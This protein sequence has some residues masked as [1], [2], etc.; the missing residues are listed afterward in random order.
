MANLPHAWAAYAQFQSKLSRLHRLNDYSWGLEGA[1]NVIFEPDF[2]PHLTGAEEFR[3]AVAN[4]SRKK[5]NHQSRFVAHEEVGDAPDPND[6][7]AQILAADALRVIED[8]INNPS[9]L[10]LID[11][12]AIGHDYA[13]LAPLL[14]QGPVSLRSRAMRLR[15]R[16]AHLKPSNMSNTSIERLTQEITHGQR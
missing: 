12:I 3:R 14:G 2:S 7:V 1:L 15:R 5:R 9:D 6:M 13:E 10:N 4:A 16:F 8:Q 11:G